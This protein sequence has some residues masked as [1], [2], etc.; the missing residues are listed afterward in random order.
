MPKIREILWGGVAFLLSATGRLLWVSDLRV[1]GSAV[2]PPVISEAPMPEPLEG[3]APCVPWRALAELAGASAR[4]A[5]I[6][7]LQERLEPAAAGEL[8]TV[9]PVTLEEAA[10]AIGEPS[11]VD[12]EVSPCVVRFE[13]GS[14]RDLAEDLRAHLEEAYVIAWSLEG[15]VQLAV[16]PARPPEA[17]EAA[18]DQRLF[19][20]HL[21]SDAR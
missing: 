3:G 9:D 5:Q 19:S 4:L 15:A 18:A 8:P 2:P 13:G 7:A 6:R 10:R 16:W 11:W 1:T 12:C 21:R 14:P 20:L 17:I